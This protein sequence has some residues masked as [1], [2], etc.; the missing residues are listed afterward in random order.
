MAFVKDI[1]NQ[2]ESESQ[3]IAARDRA[4]QGE[5]AKANLLAVM[6]HE[7]RTPLNGLLGTLQ[8]LRGTRLNKRQRSFVDVMDTS[9]HLLLD[10][11][12]DVLDVS[13]VDSV[14]AKRVERTFDIGEMLDDVKT[15]L[16]PQA[17][18]RSNQFTVE[19]LG[20]S[21]A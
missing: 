10:H 6:S 12:N 7:M 17:D 4:I 13:R 16:K 2:V 15:K 20:S 18:K 3:L 19:I 5:Q 11:V 9:D 1:S 8:L 14:K 21:V